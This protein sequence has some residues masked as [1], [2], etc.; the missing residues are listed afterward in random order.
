MSEKKK[1]KDNKKGGN[2]L[3]IVIVVLLGLILIGGSV[4]AGAFIVMK[5]Q[6]AAVSAN[7]NEKSKVDEKTYDLKEFL[8][9][10]S[11]EGG[12]RYLKAKISIGYDKTNKKL[13]KEIEPKVDVLRD[14]VNTV[15]RSKKTTDITPA[16]TETLKKE[17]M[18]KLNPLLDNGRITNVYFYEILVQ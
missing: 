7:T 8:V 17:I 1:V 14:A 3:K 13:D 11:D 9:N 4:F 6:P 16:S 10:L 15:L 12:K 2:S 5:R 18:D